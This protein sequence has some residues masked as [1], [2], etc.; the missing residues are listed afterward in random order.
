MSLSSSSARIALLSI[1]LA[2]TSAGVERARE[3]REDPLRLPRLFGDGMVVQ[4]GVRIPV[5][6]WAPPGSVV[7]IALGGRTDRAT[8]DGGGRWRTSFPPMDAGG[9]YELAVRAS[10][11]TIMVHDVLVGDVWVA[12]GQSN[13]EL[14]VSQAMNAAAEIA[15]AHDPRIRHFK[16]PN[17]W[18]ES[19]RDDVPGGAWAAADPGHVGDFSAVAYYFAREL[20]RS[21]DVPIG[22]V[23]AS[24]SGSN[25]ET[26][27][28]RAGQ[29]LSDA[30]WTAIADGERE[31]TRRIRADLLARLGGSLPEH[32]AGMDGERARWAAPDLDDASWESLPVPSVWER[33]GYAGMDG[34]AWY[35]TTFALAD[36]DVARPVR[37]S[38]GAIDD[39]DIT[40]VNGVEVGRTQ[41]Y[42]TPRTY[43]VPRGVLRAG[44]NVLAIRVVDG[45]GDGGPTGPAPRVHLDVGDEMRPLA[46]AWKFRVGEVAMKPDGQ[47]IN[48]I[49]TVLYNAMLRPL[50]HYPIAG[51]LWY[52][53]ESN[54][55]DDAQ[56]AAYR[57]QFASLITS[58]RGEWSGSRRDFPFLWVQLPGYTQ[59]DATPPLHAAWATQRESM[60]AALALPNT[61]QAVIIDLGGA[62]ALHPTNKQDVGRRLAL[63][64]RKVAY[65]ERALL[66]SGPTYRRHTVQGGRAIVELDH[67][68]G[69]LVSRAADGSVGGFALAGADRVFVWANARID[70][71]RVIVWSD[72]VPAPV[73]VRYA[74][75]NNPSTANLYN[76]DGL[77]AAPFRTD[78]W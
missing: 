58:W 14:T 48:K 8:A 76:R 32:D 60:S 1:A 77:P 47:H 56:A 22:V 73:A 55:N 50:Q 16:V 34:V 5:W 26:W 71:S 68:G 18:S 49:P 40:W 38:L 62:T 35:R 2:A 39:D 7:T 23:D 29:G 4:R 27:I 30:A 13:M 53:G 28:S 64:A 17:A 67:V 25:I 51:V 57:Q 61:G 69:G 63:V 33:A 46:G 21:V 52:Q 12:S 65:G 41:G 44:R 66:A 70:G 3:R 10:G 31:R 6:G 54:A 9:P 36:A 15:A 42:D 19:P 24:W 78:A 72:R 11:T 59:P 75:A 37:L 45:G 74:W 20:R 43:A